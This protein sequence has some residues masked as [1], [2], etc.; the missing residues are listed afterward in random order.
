[1]AVRGVFF[2]GGW[3]LFKPANDDWFVT[4]EFARLADMD[5]YAAIPEGRKAAAFDSALEYLRR[6]HRLTTEAE[7]LEQ[8][9]V[10]YETVAQ[11]LPELGLTR[12]AADEVARG[13][14]FNME[15]YIFF[16]DAKPTLQALKG[17]YRL[18]V[19]SDI[20]PSIRHILRAGG[21]DGSFDTETFSCLLGVRKPD[22]RMY[23]D[24]LG[25][26]GLPASE[27]VFIDDFEDNLAGAEACGIR[28]ILIRTCPGAADSGRFCAVDSLSEVPGLLERLE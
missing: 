22:P 13:K 21:I 19:I 26:M 5:A 7:E 14:V 3:T 4:R 23:L 1:M 16:G 12:E 27:T 20:W 24:A 15:N 10:F 25:K 2:D 9:T 11:A 28:P 17:R 8:F 18:G 6:H